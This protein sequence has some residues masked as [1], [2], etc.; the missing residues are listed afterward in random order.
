MQATAAESK[1]KSWYDPFLSLTGLLGLVI[2]I[3][4]VVSY[5]RDPQ[6]TTAVLTSTIGW[7][8]P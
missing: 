7:P 3:A 2:L 6:V 5:V 8:R 1:Q 4:I